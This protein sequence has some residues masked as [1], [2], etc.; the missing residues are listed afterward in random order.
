V[1][2][3]ASILGAS[4]SLAELSTV[5][6]TPSSS[7]V[8]NIQEAVRAGVLVEADE[9]LAFHHELV[10]QA[11]YS[12]L[13][14]SVRRALHLQAGRALA[15]AEAPPGQ[16]A[17]HLAIG[18]VPGDQEAIQWLRRAAQLAGRRAPSV[19]VGL[20]ERATELLAATDPERVSVAAELVAIL[21]WSGR[22]HEAEAKAH[23]LLVPGLAA[24]VEQTL[25]VTLAEA[26]LARGRARDAL[27]EMEALTQA[28]P[29]NDPQRARLLAFAAWTRLF[30]GDVQGAVVWE[31]EALAAAE[32]EEDEGAR[33]VALCGLGIAGHLLGDVEQAVEQG[34]E[35]IQR[36]ETDPT[37]HLDRYPARLFLGWAL[38]DCDRMV[39]ADH[40]LREGIRRSEELGLGVHLPFYHARL[41]ALRFVTGEW[42]DAVAE[43]EAAIQA[44]EE[45]QWG[46]LIRPR[47]L[48]A[49]IALHRNQL[50]AA[51]E[52]LDLAEREFRSVGR[53]S[54]SMQWSRVLFLQLRSG[55]ESSETA[56]VLSSVGW[57]T[58]TDRAG[59]HRI[60]VKEGGDQAQTVGGLTAEERRLLEARVRR[61]KAEQRE[62]LR[63][64]IVLAAAQGEENRL[65]AERL[66][67][68]PNTAS[69]RRKR[70]FQEGLAGLADRDRPGRPRAVPP[71][72][73]RRGQGDRL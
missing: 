57:W 40:V 71:G 65:I 25:R 30:A 7:L 16:V 50:L 58:D 44:G 11:V 42:D 59:G 73:H 56:R 8:N 41:G 29:H 47:S 14:R 69:K 20:L 60:R 45:Q 9:R 32:R 13:P 10:R 61:P 62:V 23:E 33:S 53:C 36:A 6:G 22:L 38:Q 67:I 48:L 5:L 31:H 46:A 15:A 55:T 21:A 63:A 66:G 43:L 39:D 35:A 37:H 17:A 54:T 27:Q 18:A 26:M 34:T 19:A 4:F 72:G 28:L 51:E 49:L 68:A 12:N 24:E 64:R 1:L 2:R 3:V 52:G 70:F